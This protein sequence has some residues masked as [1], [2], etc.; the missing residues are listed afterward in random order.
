MNIICNNIKR[1]LIKIAFLL[2]KYMTI[3]K[4][5]N[6]SKKYVTFKKEVGLKGSI[7]S[8]FKREK[9]TKTAVDAFGLRIEKGEFVALIGPNGAGK[10]TLIKMLTGIIAPSSGDVSVLGYYPNDL[11]DDFKRKFAIVMGQ[12][13]DLRHSRSRVPEKFELFHRTIFS[14]GSTE[15]SGTDLVPGRTDENGTHCSP[16]TQSGSAVFR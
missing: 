9:I 16:F 3:I 4:T 14:T 2:G 12:K 8:L 13:G 7:K 5:T 11:K 1:S 10:T 15:C 6:L